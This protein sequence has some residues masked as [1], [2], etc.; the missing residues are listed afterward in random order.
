MCTQKVASGIRRRKSRLS[1]F[2]FLNPE[3]RNRRNTA[4]AVEV[5]GSGETPAAL[6]ERNGKQAVGR[7]ERLLD[8]VAVVDVD[9]HHNIVPLAKLMDAKD[10]DRDGTETGGLT[11]FAQ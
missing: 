3:T 4:D 11:F 6:V 10:A 7:V 2:Q 1:G 5:A 9:V 8:P